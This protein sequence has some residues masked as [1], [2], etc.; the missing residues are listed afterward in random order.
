MSELI[1]SVDEFIAWTKELKGRMF[2]YRGLPDADWPIES[3]AYRRLRESEKNP[4]EKTFP[5]TIFQGY[6]NELLDRASL[7]EFRYQRDRELSD[8]ELLAELQH[9]GAA[10][11]LIDFTR[12]ALIALWFACREERKKD[13]KVVVAIAKDDMARDRFSTVTSKELKWKIEEFFKEGKLWQWTPGGPS[14][15]IIAQQSVFVFGEGVIG[16]D[17]YKEIQIDAESK[18]PIILTLEKLFGIKGEHLFN[19]LAGYALCN[20]HDK[21]YDLSA[22]D[23]FSY[24]LQFEQQGQSGK[25]IE[26]YGKAIEKDPQFAEAYNNRGIVKR[27]SG[28][29][30]GAIKDYNKAIE[31]KPLF[32]EA[33]N[34]RGV[35]KRELKKYKE[36]V[37]DYDKAI[38]ID[39]QCAEAYN[40]RGVAKGELKEYEDAIEDY[41]KAIEFMPL[42]FAEA[43]YNRGNAKKD[44]KDYPGA[45]EDYDEAIKINP[46]YAKAYY[47][48]GLAKFAVRDRKGAR[49]DWERAKE[50]NPDFSIP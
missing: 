21:P 12:N 40:N 2:L 3:S 30:S 15:R 32:A 6:I 8:L 50:I 19:D 16:N 34:N 47:N 42:F 37:E 45:I 4:P 9:Y 44:L 23:Y 13:G 5:Q 39:S 28:D 14:S 35:A 33:Y 48:R 49:K 36:A 11:C 10:T 43:Y 41:D 1:K 17:L 22:K 24:A 27:K 20:A 31:L 7:Q 29:Y 46:R 26:Y 25:A 38:E 18:E